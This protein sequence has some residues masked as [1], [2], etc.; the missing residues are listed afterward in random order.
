TPSPPRFKTWVQTIVVL[1]NVGGGKDILPFPFSVR[2]RIFLIKRIRQF[3]VTEVF[4]QVDLVRLFD[5]DR[6]RAQRFFQALRKHCHGSLPPLP[7]RTELVSSI[8][9]WCLV[10]DTSV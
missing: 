8:R 2:L 10:L 9:Y 6:M 4:S 3:D 1:T 7:C 5:L